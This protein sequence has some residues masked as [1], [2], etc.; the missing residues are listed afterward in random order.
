MLWEDS[1]PC[2]ASVHYTTNKT[3]PEPANYTECHWLSVVPCGSW[4]SYRMMVM[5]MAKN[6]M[7]NLRADKIFIK[8]DALAYL[9]FIITS[10]GGRGRGIAHH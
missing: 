1:L 2:L 3:T 4:S 6:N 5:T 9:K 8:M 7:N 10:F